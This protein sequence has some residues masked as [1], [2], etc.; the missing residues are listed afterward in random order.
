MVLPLRPKYLTPSEVC[1]H[2]TADDCWVSFLGKVY[3][4]TLLCEKYKGDVLLKPILQAAGQDISHWFNPKTKDIRTHVD[5]V[6]QCTIPYT[7]HGRFVHIAPPYPSSDWANDFGRPWWK[8]DSY[9][10]GVLSKKTRRI[11]IVNTLTSQEHVIEVCSEETINEILQRYLIYNSHAASYTWK[12]N[13]VNVNMDKTLEDNGITD[14]D[15]QFYQLR[16]ND[17]EFLHS[18]HI[19]FNDDL[20]EA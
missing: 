7:P 16:M 4:L 11:R 14:Q 12:Y 18:L 3:D 1:I 5:P 2:N 19:Y 9:C 13:G 10:I 17:D 8:D 15:E 6:T 20:T